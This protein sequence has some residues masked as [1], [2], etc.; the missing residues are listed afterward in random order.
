MMV[1]ALG[2]GSSP[3]LGADGDPA[4]I[5]FVGEIASAT[6]YNHVGVVFDKRLDETVPV[7]FDHFTVTIDGT[8][9]DPV[10]GDYLLSGLAGTGGPFD[11]SGTTLIRL[12]LPPSASIGPS[13]EFQ[14]SYQEGPA[15]LRDLS[16]TPPLTPQTVA[17]EVLDMGDFE[18]LGA[19]V[20]AANA[21]NR[22]TLLFTGQ[23]DLDSIPALDDFAV[24]VDG[25]ADAVSLVEPRFTDIGL[26][27]VDLVLA[28]PVQGGQVVDFTYTAD[29]DGNRFTARNGGL[30]LGSFSQTGVALFIPP[31]TATAALAAG[32]T[33]STA[34][35]APS[36]EDPLVTAVTSPI[37]GTVTI[38]EVTVDPSPA[39]YTFFG[40][41]VVITAPVATDAA[42]P[43]LLTFKLDAS[44]VPDGENA[45]SIV[46][47]RTALNSTEVV[48]ECDD[49]APAA[50]AAVAS[51][52]VWQ[53]VDEVGGG[54][55]ITVATLQA[56]KWNFGRPTLATRF[57]S[58]R[59]PV[60]AA[61]VRN[62]MKAGT[63]VPLKFSLGG[64]RGLA[65]F[66]PGSPSS[67]PV[68]CDT[69]APY[70]GVEVTVTAGGS[71]LSYDAASDTYTYTWKTQKE[72]T[73][74][75]KLTMTFADGSV[76]E[77]IFQ[78]RP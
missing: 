46:I 73:G 5:L 3:V 42:D 34:T 62:G 35:G 67:Q 66:A 53:R 65:I 47:L 48:P 4:T 76:Q 43:L 20:D 32:E 17:G 25:V 6:S 16:L 77:A 69:G 14:V 44:L 7:P 1:T 37:A 40:E 49:I 52:C 75:R 18:F 33:L 70:D 57:D 68:T 29:P 36:P 61:P 8:P 51:P 27:V 21:T 74:C 11:P 64:N 12:D 9:H 19:L 2:G 23:V 72:W 22:L 15:P 54:V 55:S 39:G 38:A 78:F 41:Q 59:P 56:S 31:T 50:A 24:T 71:S 13:S 60:D 58:F 63:A 10:G 30:V 28:T 26:G 45:Q